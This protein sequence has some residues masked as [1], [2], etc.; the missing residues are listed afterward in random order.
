MMCE[1][2]S[3]DMTQN[4]I[5]VAINR[6]MKFSDMQALRFVYFFLLHHASS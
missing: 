3:L 5:I 6:I 4:E 1:F 2:G